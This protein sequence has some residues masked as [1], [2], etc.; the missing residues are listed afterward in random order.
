[1]ATNRLEDQE[2]SVLSLHLLQLSLVYVNTLMIQRVMA[3]RSWRRRL[4]PEDLRALTPLFYV[5]INPYGRFD[6]DMDARLDIE[7]ARA[8]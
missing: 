6:L 8:A 5:H 1:V 2:I 4:T 3:D 7:E